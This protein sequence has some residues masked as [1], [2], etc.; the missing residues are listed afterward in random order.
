MEDKQQLTIIIPAYN[1]EGSLPD[2]LPT[3]TAFCR[4]NDFRLIIVDDASKDGTFE[5]LKKAE[6]ENPFMTVIHHK[7]NHGYGGAIRSGI[8]A[9]ETP[10][11][12]TM[13]ADGQHLPVFILNLLKRRQET[14]ADLVIGSRGTAADNQE[15]AFRAFGKKIIRWVAR[16]L[17]DDMRI[18]DLNSGM[19]LYDTELAKSYLPLCPDS[20]AFADVMTLVFLQQ[21]HLV[22]ETPI[23]VNPRKAGKSTINIKTAMDTVLQIL[24]IVMVF[25]PAKIFS[26]IGLAL[27]LI[28]TLWAI[29]IFIRGRG[30][31]SASMMAITAGFILIMLGLLAEQLAQIRRKDL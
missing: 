11:C 22:V 13:D 7:V 31:S 20:M 18:T 14:D 28:G 9:C 4:T 12:A 29:P 6:A 27:I 17:V 16:M 26:P 1:E 5:L 25:N 30:L 21:K 8:K 19:K 24:N 15:D 23:K 2:F 10:L 3:I